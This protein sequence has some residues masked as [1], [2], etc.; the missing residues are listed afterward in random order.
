VTPPPGAR[1]ARVLT[2][3]GAVQDPAWHRALLAVD[4]AGFLPPTVWGQDGDD[5]YSPLA[6]SSSE[7]QRWL[8]QDVS[9]VTQVDDG[10]P[11]GED[12]RGFTPSSSIS[13]PSLV[14][15]MLQALDV[16]DGM[17]VLE[18]GTGTGY[19]TALLC[20]RLGAEN[21]TSIEVDPGVAARAAA[22]LT[23]AGYKPHLIVGDGTEAVDAG[24]YD[25]MLA[26]VAVARV[27]AAWVAAL[28]PG[29]LLVAPWAPGA[30]FAPG[31]L[32][33]LEAGD[34]AARGRVIG[35]AAFMLARDHR[36]PVESWVAWVDEDDPAAVAGTI[37]A[38][39][40]VVSE[41]NTG[42]TV[43]LGHLVPGLGYASFEAAESNV[44]AAGEASVYVFDRAGSWALGEYVPHGAPYESLRCGPRDLWA[45]IGAAW[46]VW[47][48]ADR[49]G[50]D[51]LG[52][53]VTAE[54]EHLLWVDAPEH[55]LVLPGG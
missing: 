49:P 38:N 24:P 41:R 28:S 30:G 44:G 37:T 22:N 29:G 6:L 54:G 19:N 16:E 33:R 34:G 47:Q 15:A 4:R 9:I 36:P 17:R 13:Q 27:P 50:R 2:V 23:D 35:D 8:G 43:V 26:T 14:V 5:W 18:I 39:P 48:A 10:R 7:V 40:R 20:E 1:I 52:L 31:V 12:G 11:R 42:W 46:E 53:T 32:V 51:R 3:K 21:V 25:R 45:E 55:V